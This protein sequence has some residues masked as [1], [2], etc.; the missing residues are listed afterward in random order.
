M[1]LEE[2]GSEIF[3]LKGREFMDF[4]QTSFNEIK[5]YISILDDKELEN[6]IYLLINDKRKNVSTLGKRILLKK[7]KRIVE[8]ER[9]KKMYQFDRQFGEDKLIAGV[10]EVGRGPLAG[11]IVAASVILPLG[12]NKD[13]ELLLGINDSKKLSHD[14]REKLYKIIIDNA[15]DYNISLI[16]KDE[17]DE[18]GIGYCNNE[19]LKRACEGLKTKPDI[20]ISDGYPIKKSCL[21]NKYVIKGDEKSASIACAS[22]IAKVYRDN[23][24]LNLSKIYPQYGFD[25]NVGYGTKEHIEAIKKYGPSKI[26]RLSFLG[27]II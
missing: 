16:E 23:L 2:V 19:V 14:K 12:F 13:D 7:E 1:N 3:L 27:N 18:K 11:P 5:K 15:I 21:Y 6:I 8:I 26:H 22:I 17:I 24:M 4:S 20:V 10:D 25:K 9:V